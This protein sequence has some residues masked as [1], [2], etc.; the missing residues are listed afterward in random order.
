MSTYTSNT[1]GY[2]SNYNAYTKRIEL[3]PNPSAA[4]SLSN[5]QMSKEEKEGRKKILVGLSCCLFFTAVG[6]FVG[7]SQLSC[8]DEQGSSM[9]GRDVCYIMGIVSLAADVVSGCVLVND[10][11]NGRF[12]ALFCDNE[13]KSVQKNISKV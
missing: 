4:V 2:Q 12:K 9:C 6:F 1:V 10:I 7:G 8:G 11:T 13:K 5:A 3:F